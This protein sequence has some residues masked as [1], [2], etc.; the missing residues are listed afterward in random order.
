M[1]D[2]E[3]HER[4]SALFLE[5]RGVEGRERESRLAAIED[6][7]LREEVASLLGH[8]VGAGV[9]TLTGAAG[10]ETSGP[11]PAAIGPYR[12]VGRLGRGGSGY[13]LL[14]EQESPVR[15]R[16]AI[17][18]VPRAMVDPAMAARFEVERRALES[19]EHPNIARILDAG[20][21]TEGLPYLVMDFVDG[22]PVTTFC[23]TQGL[24]LRQR[25]TLMLD[26]ADAVQ[27]AHQR[28]VIHRD[29]KPANI[30][31]SGDADRWT[32][33]VLDFGIAKPVE[34]EGDEAI[35]SGLLLG[36]PA[37]MAPEQTGPGTVDT[38]A[39]VY[40]LGS[41]LYELACGRPPLEPTTDVLELVRRIR[42]ESPVPAS[43]RRSGDA[44]FAD[45]RVP[46]AMLEDLDR[47]IGRALEKSPE[48]RY[49]TVGELADDIRRVLRREP[50]EA[51]P[52]T[53]AYRAARF[54]ERHR[55]LVAGSL[56]A[57]VACVVGVAGLAWGLIAAERQ[58]RTAV[59]Q[60]EALAEYNRFLT[61][62]L[63]AAASPEE[64]NADLTV[65]ELLDRASRGVASRLSGRPLVEASVHHTLGAAY[66]QLGEFDEAERH[67]TRALEVRRERSGADA[68]DTLRTELALAGL[69][70]HR[71]RFA[72]AEEAIA[73]ALARARAALGDKDAAVLGGL[74]DLGV[75][76]L[77]LGKASEA[78]DALSE[79][80]EGRR[81]LM[82]PSDPKVVVTLSNLAQ[83]YDAAGESE[84]SLELMR[85]ALAIAESL[86]PAPRMLLLGLS[87]NIGATYQDMGR[88]ED[89]APF[90]RRAAELAALEFGP[91][92]HVALAIRGNLAGLEARLGEPVRAAEMYT[93]V[94]E[95]QARLLGP[96]AIDTLTSRYGACNSLMLAGRL[97]EAVEGFV[98]LQADVE[99]ALGAG[100][101]LNGQTHVAIAHALRLE[102]RREDAIQHASMGVE[103]YRESFDP[104]HPRLATARQFLESLEAER[105]D[106]AD[107]SG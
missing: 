23:A 74:N 57:F 5:L 31:A 26:V 32:V 79:A 67:L 36:T 62:D 95:G 104:D 69:L 20:V 77:S 54:V 19:V 27:H 21:T 93:L 89:A 86:S 8:D 101:W 43:R 102:G 61:D 52:Q 35:T 83:A 40:A 14:G 60:S 99:R 33:R 96:D 55:P 37:Y 91:E 76:L 45:D 80:L 72:E 34:A 46:A 38:R 71:Q 15:R 56:L 87:N 73:R 10:E 103:I 25:L 82:G 100:H 48:R 1:S 51:R 59:A 17:K 63:L 42:A 13:V 18:L 50:V 97:G 68:P 28:G 75:A 107:G 4:A 2:R 30:L 98:A 70:G 88:H 90:L 29:L 49:P 58:R 65:R 9:E 81:A 3:L 66:A 44:A 106:A 105:K 7:R 94:A 24:R 92:S 84:R 85:E 78:V 64:G 39:D 53:R 47:V 16:V 11:T 12:I 41:L 22:V 6:A